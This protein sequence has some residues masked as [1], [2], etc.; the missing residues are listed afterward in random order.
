MTLQQIVINERVN[1]VMALRQLGYTHKVIGE[2]LGQSERN[3]QN[4]VSKAKAMAEQRA[5]N[6]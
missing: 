2:I 5:S 4:Y 1:I 6:E 3:I